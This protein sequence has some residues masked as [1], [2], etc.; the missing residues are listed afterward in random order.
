MTEFYIQNNAQ[1]QIQVVQL[2]SLCTILSTAKKKTKRKCS[3][4]HQQLKNMEIA[5]NNI[6]QYIAR[7]RV[8]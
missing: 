7:L 1:L 3:P 4:L 2:I 5:T 6:Q 8:V